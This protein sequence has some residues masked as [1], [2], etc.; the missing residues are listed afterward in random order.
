MTQISFIREEARNKGSKRTIKLPAIPASGMLQFTRDHDKLKG[1][2]NQ[3]GEF[4]GITILNNGAVDIEISLDFA[5]GKTYP[6]PGAASIGLDEVTFQGFNIVNLDAVNPTISNKITVTAT[7][8]RS[9]LREKM[10]TK[11]EIFRG[12]L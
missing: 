9:M 12:V 2:I 8:E 6:V 7:F 3:Y 11:K 1:V 10:R 5:E 4:N